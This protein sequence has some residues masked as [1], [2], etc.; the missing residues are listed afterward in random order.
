MICLVLNW[1]G[2]LAND[3]C[4]GTL[5]LW[6][7]HLPF[8]VMRKKDEWKHRHSTSSER[9]S[10]STPF[11]RNFDVSLW[12][13]LHRH[14]HYHWAIVACFY[15][16]IPKAR[17]SHTNTFHAPSDAAAAV[18]VAAVVICF[19]FH[20]HFMNFTD[21]CVSWSH[22]L[23]SAEVSSSSI[24]LNNAICVSYAIVSFI[25]CLFLFCFSHKERSSHDMLLTFRPK[26]LHF[27][28]IASLFLSLSL[29]RWFLIQ[30]SISEKF[31]SFICSE[32]SFSSL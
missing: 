22:L 7:P 5:F 28:R 1:F 25:F 26:E 15:W 24:A 13:L 27:Y 19:H 30:T 31:T 12:T 9:F 2:I 4:F 8:Q 6:F 3:L 18:A 32:H 20:F 29:S 16:D 10:H 11:S 17:N 23:S 14:I 21:F